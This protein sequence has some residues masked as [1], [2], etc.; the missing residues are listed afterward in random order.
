MLTNLELC[1][2]NK[3]LLNYLDRCITF[4]YQYAW[5]SVCQQKFCM[6]R[7]VTCRKPWWLTL[8]V[9]CE[10]S[11][12]MTPYEWIFQLMSRDGPSK[13]NLGYKYQTMT[14]I[15]CYSHLKTVN[16]TCDLCFLV[17]TPNLNDRFPEV[18][19]AKCR[20]VYHY[21]YHWESCDVWPIIC[22][23]MVDCSW[24]IMHMHDLLESSSKV[25]NILHRD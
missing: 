14:P 12:C 8:G 23:I 3:S 1:F 22:S 17:C 11:S 6:L 16:L 25:R 24:A 19:Q 2:Q 13:K 4:L 10:K 7:A 9:I 18:S 15:F 21:V 5:L 20:F